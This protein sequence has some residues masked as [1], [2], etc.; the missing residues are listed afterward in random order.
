MEA[1]HSGGPRLARRGL[2]V[3][4]LPEDSGT[5]SHWEDL[6]GEEVDSPAISSEVSSPESSPRSLSTGG[7][8]SAVPLHREPQPY[9][10]LTGSEPRLRVRAQPAR[11]SCVR[12]EAPRQYAARIPAQSARDQ[13][14]AAER[15]FIALVDRTLHFGLLY[16][17]RRYSFY[18]I[19][20]LLANT[21]EKVRDG[22]TSADCVQVRRRP[23]H[24]RAWELAK[25]RLPAKNYL[26]RF[27]WKYLIPSRE[28]AAVTGKGAHPARNQPRTAH[29]K[30]GG[31]GSGRRK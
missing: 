11:A 21:A 17:F 12:Q 1:C 6:L 27:K 30:A 31:R 26:P 3:E 29:G 25:A 16:A 19:G 5:D 23:V 7:A 22:R 2:T 8:S 14:T 20:V 28:D 18:L 9:S 4:E 15:R 24:A 10:S 13:L